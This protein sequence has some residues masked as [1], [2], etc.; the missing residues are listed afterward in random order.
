MSTEKKILLDEIENMPDELTN[1]VMDFVNYLK[2]S[3]VDIEGPDEL[4]IKSKKDLNEKLQKGLNDIKNGRT[5][6]L[7]ETF[8]MIDNL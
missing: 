2:M 6:T 4:N 1:Q 7:E 5:Y 3:Y 8:D